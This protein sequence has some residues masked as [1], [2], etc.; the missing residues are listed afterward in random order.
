MNAFTQILRNGLNN[1]L[2]KVDIS[3]ITLGRALALVGCAVAFAIAIIAVYM[4][5]HRKT[6]FRG[7]M[8]T[9]ILVLGPIVGVIVVCVGSNLARAI[10]I[11][12]GLALIRFR[13][14]VQDPRDLIYI[15][16]SLAAGMAAG[17]GFIG[18]GVLAIG[19]VLV[20]L[21]IVHFCK[22]ECI[23]GRGRRLRILVPEDLS[24]H[25]VF[26]PILKKYCKTYQLNRIKTVDYGTLVELDYRVVMNRTVDI[27]AMMDEIRAC[28]GNMTV[29]ITENMVSEAY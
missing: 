22:I 13:T 25:D 2:Y 7:S 17:T 27:K 4:I 29:S 11:G 24:Y 21:L 10:S 23:G 9:T 5:T 1:I 28:N 8:M 19:T 20:L 16:L 3:Q 12:G 15:F 14:Q 6:G 26:E 18:F